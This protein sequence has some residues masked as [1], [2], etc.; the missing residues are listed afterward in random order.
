MYA[1]EGSCALCA[2]HGI[3][4]AAAGKLQQ[5]LCSSSKLEL[6]Q[7]SFHQMCLLTPGIKPSLAK[8]R[9][10]ILLIL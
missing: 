5:Q 6:D 7:L 10:M 4:A 1:M 3:A 9:N 2:K 8:V